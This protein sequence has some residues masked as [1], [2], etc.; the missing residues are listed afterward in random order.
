MRKD[1]SITL[2]ETDR[3][4]LEALV[5]D[6]NTAQKH[7]WRAR[8]VLRNALFAQQIAHTRIDYA[9]ALP[10]APTW[11]T[12]DPRQLGQVFTHDIRATGVEY[13]PLAPPAR[14]TI[15]PNSSSVMRRPRAVTV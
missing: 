8:I 1:I 13:T 4:R 15:S 3:Q 2:G 5:A 6:R 7:V 9:T 11:I 10:E 14:T 12:G